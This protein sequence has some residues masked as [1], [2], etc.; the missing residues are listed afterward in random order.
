[1]LAVAARRNANLLAKHRLSLHL[2]DG[3]TLPA[4]DHSVDAVLAVHTIYFWPDAA[5]TLTEAARVLR[6]GGR[7]VLAF[8]AGDH[9]TPGRF[10][11]A[12]YH[13]PTTEQATSWL[14][15]AGFAGIRTH[16]HPDTALTVI[17]LTA[18]TPTNGPSPA[19]RDAT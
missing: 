19:S 9:P 11:P 5:A 1:M 17:W 8:R 3:T 14:R 4:P 13:V 18:N 10:H 16:T 12:I 7:L 6:P 2:G 15:A